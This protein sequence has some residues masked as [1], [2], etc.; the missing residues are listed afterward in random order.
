[1]SRPERVL[2]ALT[3]ALLV[4]GTFAFGAVYPWAHRPLSLGAIVAGVIGIEFGH[5]RLAPHRWIFFSLIAIVLI[6]ALQLIPLSQSVLATISPGT[7]RFLR[8]YD[9]RYVLGVATGPDG[10]PMEIPVSHALSIA[11]AA[12]VMAIGL[13][14]GFIVLLAGLLRGLT[15][16]S[17]LTLA[18]GIVWI[19][20]LVALAGILQKLILGD[21][22]SLGM[23]IYGVWAPDFKLTTPFG[24]FINKNHFAGWVLMVLP[25]AFGLVMG[26]VDEQRGAIG[27]GLRRHLVWLST[28][29]AGAVSL[30]VVAGALMT[31]SLVMTR[32]RSGLLCLALLLVAAAITAG[33]RLDSRGSRIAL[34]ALLSVV[35]VAPLAWAGTDTAIARL[36]AEPSSVQLRLHIWKVAAAIFHDFALFGS[37]LNSFSVAAIQYQPPGPLHYQEAHNDYLQLLAEG[38]LVIGLCA[39]VAIL[40]AADGIARRF[41]RDDDRTENYWVRAGA[42]LG[43]VAIGAQSLVEFSLQMP[44]NALLFTLLLA[45]ALHS[46]ARPRSARS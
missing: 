17:V 39:L 24:P 5:R 30:I 37:G 21:D 10:E 27:R 32:S 4:W 46:P 13:L 7:D 34:V 43:L 28:P 19:G 6:A 23:K 38:G 18:R 16:D 35:V 33:R 12:T 3:L 8:A 25:L 45:I 1:M 20:T 31:L 22:P 44:G 42:T 2:I 15:R 41:S 14:G 11:P 36:A 9:L 29:D 26:A 40:F